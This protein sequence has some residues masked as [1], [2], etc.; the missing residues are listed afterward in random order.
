MRTCG[1]KKSHFITPPEVHFPTCYVQ[2]S[3]GTDNVCCTPHARFVANCLLKWCELPVCSVRQSG[4][5]TGL[6]TAE[7]SHTVAQLEEHCSG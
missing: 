3:S 2:P 4:L 1:P 5:N 7:D 6:A